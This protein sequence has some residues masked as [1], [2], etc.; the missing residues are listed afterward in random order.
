MR[1]LTVV[2]A[3]AAVCAGAARADSPPGVP[4]AGE[5]TATLL[6]GARL[7]PQG[8]FI[9]DQRAAGY[10][11]F[12]T[13]TQP[14]F[15]LSLGYAPEVDFRIGIDI[16]YALDK[17]YM[18]AGDL[19]LHSVTIIFAADASFFRRSWITLYGGGGLGYSLNTLQQNGGPSVEANS[20]AGHVCIGARFPLTTNFALVLEDR[21]TLAYAGLPASGSGI[22]Y[23]GN[24]T[25]INVGGNL[26]S[27][28]LMF[29]YTDPEDAKRPA[30]R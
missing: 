18:S 6:T 9:D 30:H 22:N 7:V 20:T 17:I 25:S 23:A 15:L 27:I 5:A 13:F 12:K 1:A 2:A 14:G 24:S 28:G 16:G 26:L 10:H 3:A 11:P 4:G 19:S 8:G 29:H 21:Y